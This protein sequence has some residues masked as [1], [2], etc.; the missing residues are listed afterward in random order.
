MAP[1]A[2]LTAEAEWKATKRL[3]RRYV[4]KSGPEI[5]ATLSF[6]GAFGSLANAVAAEG[7]WT[8]K[9]GGFLRP[10]VSVRDAATERDLGVF[11]ATWGGDGVLR[12]GAQPEYKWSSEGIW[13]TRWTWSGATGHGLVHLSPKSVLR[14]TALAEVEPGARKDKWTGLLAALGWYLILLT[15]EDGSAGAIIAMG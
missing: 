4:L 3:A 11:E 2:K 14:S 13:R 7:H 1:F 6:A 8:F 10:R 5:F 12:L 9:R 15:A